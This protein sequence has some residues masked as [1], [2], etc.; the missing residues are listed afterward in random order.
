VT[1]EES[2]AQ[3]AGPLRGSK[4]SELLAQQLVQQIADKKLQPGDRLPPEAAMLRQ[5]RV[6]RGTL[7]ECLRLLEMQGL[8]TIRSGPRGG[9]TVAAFDAE[10]L[11]RTMTVHFQVNGVTLRDL[12]EA[13]TIME[14]TMARLAAE[15]VNPSTTERLEAVLEGGRASHGDFTQWLRVNR[16][17]HFVVSSC[18]GNGALDLVA[19]ALNDIYVTR[20]ISVHE[21]DPL[22]NWEQT[23]K[24]HEAIGRA[25]MTGQAARAERL[26]RAHITKFAALVSERF[27][28]LLE[29]IVSWG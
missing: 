27:P 3:P 20:R 4:L 12:V 14:P 6:G 13:R 16:E 25:I 15:H 1:A 26:M 22:E 7:R 8:I 5:Y 17:F 10:A 19:H 23:Q 21:D 29:T 28:W 18:S 2:F 24:E 11:A 9:P